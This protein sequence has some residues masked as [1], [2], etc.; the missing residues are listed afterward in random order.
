MF[1]CV[2]H[3]CRTLKSFLPWLNSNLDLLF[4]TVSSQP[5]L[6]VPYEALTLLSVTTLVGIHAL[7]PLPSHYSVSQRDFYFFCLS[8][9]GRALHAGCGA[10]RTVA[11]PSF[12]ESSQFRDQTPVS[13]VSC[14]GRQVAPPGKHTFNL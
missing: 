5:V 3:S 12:T 13:Y 2:L 10:H 1:S 8:E 9:Q 11:M 4:A 6:V 14:I 7:H